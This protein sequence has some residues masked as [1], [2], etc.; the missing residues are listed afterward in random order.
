MMSVFY[1]NVINETQK[2]FAQ[3]KAKGFLI[4]TFV[5]PVMMAGILHYAQNT[6]G[7]NI[8]SGID[9]SF[10]MLYWFTSLMLPLS[11]FTVASDLFVSEVS[12]RTLKLTLVRPI[13]R[14]K[15]Y[16]SKISA[17]GI[18]IMIQ[19][20]VL[21]LS[22][23]STGSL[24]F[25]GG[26][27]SGFFQAWLGYALDFIPLF[28]LGVF[29][30]CIGQYFNHTSGAFSFCTMLFVLAKIAV[31]FF[32]SLNAFLFTS[33]TDWHA[34]WTGGST[35]GSHLIHVTLVMLSSLVMFFTIGFYQFDIKEV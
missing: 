26:S 34:L 4:F 13:T 28:T 21:W 1:A 33:Y 24:M 22:S 17:M 8:L 31:I 7:Y 27:L 10:L 14:W 32:P 15:V 23:F 25:G 3:T 19:L 16:G 12:S 30:V 20:G 18:F 35:L 2:I 9:F 11:I 6:F 29:A 5:I